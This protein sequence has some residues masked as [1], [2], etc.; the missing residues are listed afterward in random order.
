MLR[1]LFYYLLGGVT[2]LPL[3]FLGGFLYFILTCPPVEPPTSSTAASEKGISQSA[4]GDVDLSPERKAEALLLATAAFGADVR[5]TAGAR[6]TSRQTGGIEIPAAAKRLLP[7]GSTAS[8]ATAA[9]LRGFKSG[10]LSVSRQFYPAGSAFGEE[11][12][13]AGSEAGSTNSDATASVAGVAA[14]GAAQD[15]KGKAGYMSAV[16]RGILDYRRNN[17]QPQPGAADTDTAAGSESLTVSGSLESAGQAQAPSKRSLLRGTSPNNSNPGQRETFQCVLKGPILYLYSTHGADASSSNAAAA[18]AAASAAGV[19]GTGGGEY[20]SSGGRSAGSSTSGDVHAAI[21]LRGKRVSIYVQYLG[22]VEGEPESSS[23]DGE[24]ED[25]G[26]TNGWKV[27]AP[28][29]VATAHSEAD[30]DPTHEEDTLTA[31]RAL[32][33]APL[34]S[35]EAEAAAA[36][37]RAKS[38]SRR[39]AQRR[40]KKTAAAQVRDGELFMK[41]NA[42]RIVG[43]LHPSLAYGGASKGKGK[44]KGKF[45][46]WFLFAKSATLLEDW[47][48]ALLQ[49]SFLPPD[50]A[51]PNPLPGAQ[52]ALPSALKD[53]TDPVGPIFSVMDMTKLLASLD[54]VPDPIPLRWLNAMLGRIFFSIYRTAWLEDYVTSKLMKKISRVKTP[55]FLSDVKVREVDL[56][57]TPPAFSRPMLKT[58]TGEGEASME[59]SRCRPNLCK[60]SDKLTSCLPDHDALHR[61]FAVDHLDQSYNLARLALQVLYRLSP[62]GSRHPLIGG[63]SAAAHQAATEQSPLVWLYADAQDGHW[64]RARRERTQGAVGHGDAHY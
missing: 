24:E 20:A 60:H 59:V 48:H 12:A 41:R 7:N 25:S 17:Q 50:K 22:D 21:D 27:S 58:L 56:G 46:E 52:Q 2:F 64:D 39:A 15:G 37:S 49:A 33:T 51:S 28:S 53:T 9:P 14:G 42:I 54:T 10:Q 5:K 23:D 61:I 63:E 47:Y 44:T 31:T 6:D 36:A 16:Y 8:A 32:G 30:S 43:R 45:T 34:T 40:W 55:S 13:G 1:S 26:R 29:S 19:G 38:H 62:A 11:G 57:R 18:A 4:L 3:C 35:E